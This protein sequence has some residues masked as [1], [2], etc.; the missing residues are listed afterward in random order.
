MYQGI[1][2]GALSGSLNV[3]HDCVSADIGNNRI[4]C[5]CC[6][7]IYVLALSDVCLS[8]SDIHNDLVNQL[9]NGHGSGLLE[10]ECLVDISL[11]GSG[12]VLHLP[13]GLLEFLGCQVKNDGTL[14][15]QI[16]R[17]RNL[18][19]ALEMALQGISDRLGVPVVRVQRIRIALFV[20]Y[21]QDKR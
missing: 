20:E 8:I 18:L 9:G 11:Y 10:I 12:V 3:R 17:D 21:L 19:A 13:V 4:G 5:L 7:R 1:R 6:Q 14:F 2:K 16:I 15:P